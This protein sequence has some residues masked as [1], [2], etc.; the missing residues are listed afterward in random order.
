MSL[1]GVEFAAGDYKLVDAYVTT[2]PRH[3]K[4]AADFVEFLSR[5]PAA[6]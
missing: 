1:Y 3:V 4:A 2:A 5:S 6:A